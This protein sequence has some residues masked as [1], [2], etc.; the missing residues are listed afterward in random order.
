MRVLLALSII[1]AGLTSPAPA[2]QTPAVP[3]PLP[4][5]EAAAVGVSADGLDLIAPAMQRWV[6]EGRVSGIVTMV[7]RRGRLVHWN[8]VGA[9]EIESGDSLEI[10]DIFRIYSM[11][12]PVTSVAVMM[13]AE[14]GKLAIE[15]PVSR[16]LPAFADVQVYTEDGTVA[17]RRAM[18]VQDLLRHTSG[19]GYG[20]P[21][22]RTPVDAMYDEAGVFSSDLATLV[23][24]VAALPLIDHP[25]GRWNYSVSTDVLARLVEV[26][27]GQPFDEFLSERIFVPLDMTDTGFFVPPD[28]LER[29]TAVYTGGGGGRLRVMDPVIGTSYGSKPALL[30]GG[31]GLVSTAADYVRFAQMILNG[32]ELQGTRLLQAE[33]VELMRSNHLADELIPIGFGRPNEGY[34][35][36]L[37][38]SVLVD[39]DASP[40][41]DNDGVF[42]WLGI[43]S[44][45]FWIDPE[46]ELIGLV[47]TQ[48]FP[49]GLG[50]AMEAEF[51][52]LVYDAL[53]D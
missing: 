2:H 15:D 51:Q 36:G 24:R 8:A 42:R 21:L 26:V 11:T 47:M 31:G 38:F 10:N 9:S 37:G 17:P 12:K 53:L 29:F 3:T 32:G 6:D 1:V 5:A 43:A 34:G 39:E 23:E 22:G 19:L 4:W 52:T 33:T 25:G 14:E 20:S 40:V 46:A 50:G 30:S 16:Y 45:Y 7:A 35:F 49:A 48:L 28:K 44:T 41:P 18:T 13:L 27:S